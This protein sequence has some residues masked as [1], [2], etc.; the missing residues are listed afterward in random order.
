[1]PNQIRTIR[2]AMGGLP[3]HAVVTPTPAAD[4]AGSLSEVVDAARSA[5][6][7]VA[8]D[9]IAQLETER[10]ASEIETANLRAQADLME[11]RARIRDLMAQQQAAQ[12]PAPEGGGLLPVLAG[13]LQKQTEQA[14][15]RAAHYEEA[16]ERSRAAGQAAVPASL[17]AIRTD[18]TTARQG[19]SGVSTLQE[20]MQEVRAALEVIDTFAPKGKPEATTLEATLAI[21][22]AQEQ[23]EVRMLEVEIKRQEMADQREER[24]RRLAIDEQRVATLANTLE[25]VIP[26]VAEAFATRGESIRKLGTPPAV[27]A[28]GDEPAPDGTAATEMGQCPNCG[29]GFRVTPYSLV[30]CPR[31]RQRFQTAGPGSADAVPAADTAPAEP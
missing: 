12:G 15:A 3:G 25:R 30:V 2:E 14:E 9:K 16:L 11:Q 17:D 18:L 1:M 28:V 5:S 7:R 8:I 19:G 29:T 27:A 13:I 23:H 21:Q 6:Q 24:Q 10:A 4:G 22:R 26:P 20:R 31:C